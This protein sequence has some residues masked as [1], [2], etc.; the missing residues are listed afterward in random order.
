MQMQVYIA[1]PA[2][3]SHL[4]NNTGLRGLTPDPS[5]ADAG[6]AAVCIA[7][8]HLGDNTAGGGLRGDGVEPC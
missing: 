3:P 4:G 1:K 2:A 7:A 6:L 5:D 8:A